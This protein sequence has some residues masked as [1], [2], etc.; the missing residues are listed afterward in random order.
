MTGALPSDTVKNPKLNVNP[1]SS[2][3]SARS[4]T[5]EDPQSSSH[6]LKSLPVLEVPAYAPIHNEILD[7]YVE[8]L[9]LGRGLLKT[10]SAV[11]DCRKAKITVGEGITSTDRIGARPPYYAKKNFIN[12]HLPGEWEIARNA[13]LNPF[14]DVLVFRKMVEFLGAIPINLKGNM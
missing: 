8:S 13:E 10:A 11:I 6:P 14:K 4:Y 2:V 5:M 9:E 7:K 12:Y 1:T 3:S